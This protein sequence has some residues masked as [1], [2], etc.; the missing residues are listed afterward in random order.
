MFE[1]LFPNC[2]KG[3]SQKNS[4]EKKKL[5]IHKKVKMW[6]H[7]ESLTILLIGLFTFSCSV[8]KKGFYYSLVLNTSYASCV[9]FSRSDKGGIL[10]C[11]VISRFTVVACLTYWRALSILQ[12]RR[13]P[14]ELYGMLFLP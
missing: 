1:C 8:K 11:L 5:I 3:D 10:T 9:H 13:L 12:P 2:C 6:V 4:R 7:K 14:T